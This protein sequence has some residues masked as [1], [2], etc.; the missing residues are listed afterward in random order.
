MVIFPGGSGKQQATALQD[1]G[2]K[3]IRE[4][5]RAGGGYVGI[6]AG[7][8]LATP[9]T[10]ESDNL[11]L[12]NAKSCTGKMGKPLGG[13]V[14]IELT[15]AGERVFGEF[16]GLLD[17]DYGGGPI[18]S[19]A[20]NKDLP[21]YVPLALYRTE[22]WGDESDKNTMVDTPA[23]IAARFGS[24]RVLIFSPH[25]EGIDETRPLLTRAV[26]VVAPKRTD[27]D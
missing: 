13:P 15:D 22:T 21:N 20:G 27:A 12:I 3:A 7:A 16:P 10:A 4:F 25:P 11:S 23:I 2:R 17:A 24:G 1:K 8:A 5:V 9:A 14:K 6:C 19:P 18:L 26:L